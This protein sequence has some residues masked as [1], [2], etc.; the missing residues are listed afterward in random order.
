[1]REYIRNILAQS[2]SLT[3]EQILLHIAAAA[4]LGCV[5]YVSYWYT[6]SGTAYSRK[7]NVSLVTLTIL[8]GVVMTVI[9]NNVALSLGMVGALSIIRFRTA[10]KDSRDTTYIFWAIV[11]GICCGVG[12]YLVAVIGSA[13]VFVVLLV[14]GKVRS[15]NRFLLILRVAEADADAAQKEVEE[16]YSGK[17]MLR[18]KNATHE[19][20]E[21]IFE[22][23]RSMYERCRKDGEDIIARLKKLP[24]MEYVNVVAQSDEITG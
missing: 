13:A 9:G 12:D 5:I 8:T 11:V 21:Y 15:E 7:F 4:A 2:G 6:H 14:L 3:A 22:M 16:F 20:T 17:A 19:S 1:M 23:T 10:I 18:A 24:G